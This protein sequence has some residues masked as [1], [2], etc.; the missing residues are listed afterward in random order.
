MALGVISDTH[1]DLHSWQKA[2]TLWGAVEQVL[3]AGDVLGGRPDGSLWL[4]EEIKNSPAPVLVAR[5]NCDGD[6]LEELLGWP[7]APR[8]GLIWQGRKICM[9]HGD[10]PQEFRQWALEEGADLAI[11]GHT[12]VASLTL[13]GKTWFLNPGSASLPRGRDPASV[14]LVD[15]GGLTIFTLEGFVLHRAPWGGLS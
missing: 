2:R 15:E 12:H 10:R 6:S 9:A 5:G 3:H 11:S 8:V 7:V 14:V 13:E 1:G 4:A